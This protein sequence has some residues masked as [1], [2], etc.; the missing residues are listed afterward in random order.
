MIGR[1][2]VEKLWADGHIVFSTDGGYGF[3]SIGPLALVDGPVV[4]IAG[5]GQTGRKVS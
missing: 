3:F 2:W 4:R 5:T 1:F